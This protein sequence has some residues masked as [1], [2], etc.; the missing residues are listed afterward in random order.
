MGESAVSRAADP[1]D[2]VNLQA[3]YQARR[4]SQQVPG[5]S[6]RGHLPHPP[7]LSPIALRTTRIADSSP[8][9]RK[10]HA[11]QTRSQ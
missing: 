3:R 4:P 5:G 2:R 9:W 8:A 1:R 7:E 10:P 11:P 6:S